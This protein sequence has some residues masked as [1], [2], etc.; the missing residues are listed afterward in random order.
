MFDRAIRAV[1]FWNAPSHQRNTAVPISAHYR[2]TNPLPQLTIA[3]TRLAVRSFHYTRA[4]PTGCPM[5][6]LLQDLRVAF[7][8]FLRAPAFT[9][10]ALAT[11]ALAIGATTAVFSLVDGVLLDPLG[12]TRPDRLMYI[13]ALDPDAKPMA[14]SPQDLQDFQA[15]SHAFT[16]MAA[17]DRENVSLTRSDQPSLRL[18]GAR[19]GGSFFDILG[20]APQQGRFFQRGSDTKEAPK[21]VVLSDAAW[22][23]DFG[24]DSRIVGQPLVL[25]GTS[26]EVVG[27]APPQ[28]NFPDNP[29]LWYPAVWQAWESGDTTRGFHSIHAIARLNDAATPARARLEL[30]AIAARIA[31]RWP[32]FDAKVGA[33]AIPLRDAVVGDVDRPLW[34]LLASVGVVLLI[35]CANIG[36]LMLIRASSR[37]SEIAVRSALGA[38]RGRLLRQFV[39]ESTLLAGA[40]AALGLLVA[41]WAIVAVE[42]YGPRGLPRLADVSMNGAVFAFTAAIAALVGLG[43]GILPAIHLSRPNV[44]SMLRVGA[45]WST[46]EGQRARGALVTAE[47]AL[48]TM[49]L[50]AAGLLVRSF[51]HLVAVNPGFRSEQVV[52]FDVALTGDKYQYDVPSY[53]FADEVVARLAS[54]PGTIGAAVAAN[55]PF[56]ADPGFAA[57]TS[58]TVDGRPKPAPGTEP[59]S[60]I[61]PVSPAYFQTLGMTLLRGRSFT[62]AE[63]RVDA[64]PVVV[65]NDAL[66]ARYFPGQNPIGK[67]LTFGIKHGASANPAD[68]I[69]ARGEIIGIV[70]TVTHTSLSEKPEPAA[71]FPFHVMPFGPS[72]VVRTTSDPHTLERAIRLQVAAVDHNVPIYGLQTLH[73]AVSASIAQ[74]RFYTIVSAGFAVMALLLAAVGIYGLISYGVAQRQRE[75]GLRVA[76]GATPGDVARV[77]A[78]TGVRLTLLGMILG[79]GGA[80]L[81]TRALRALLF[82]V[83]PLDPLTFAVVCVILAAAALLASW[84]PARRAAGVDPAVA[85]RA[86]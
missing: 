53:T 39:T 54:L 10:T 22:R 59:E 32:K 74:P 68:T 70:R 69:R 29:D 38:G 18:A 28:F 2:A 30:A 60:R 23:R 67:H 21:T 34:I 4:P 27:I 75:L 40:G 15:Q 31:E 56:D 61:L 65:I 63:N 81:A 51:A 42:H 78:G 17:V 14:L 85:L 57:S 62:N 73:D 36:S 41:S 48:G 86:Q 52:V 64:A 16:A 3:P 50:V 5:D 80:I 72:F 35:A 7:R 44:A 1:R 12:F 79:V 26:Y 19:V 49:L 9:L 37:Q 84:I 58:F 13:E 77:V 47:V 6:A 71:Y 11:L 66:A 83:D 82:G 25:D 20:V 45:G 43:F 55:R 46:R 8:Q 24:A 33:T 76:L